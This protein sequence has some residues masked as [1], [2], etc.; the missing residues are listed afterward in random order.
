MNWSAKHLCPAVLASASLLLAAAADARVIRRYSWQSG[1]AIDPT[2]WALN[3][4]VNT[5]PANTKPTKS[6]AGMIT[7]WISGKERYRSTGKAVAVSINT[8]SPADGAGLQKIFY[9][10]IGGTNGDSPQVL[11]G[12]TKFTGF[13]VK[14]DTGWQ[15]ANGSNPNDPPGTGIY[16]NWQGSGW[17]ALQL[18]T[19]ESNGV[20]RMYLLMGNDQMRGSG[21]FTNKGGFSTSNPQLAYLTDASGAPLTFTRGEWYKI[22]VSVK[23]DPFG[24]TGRVQAWVNDAQAA[25]WTGKVGYTP[26]SYSS[27]AVP[28]TTDGTSVEVGIYQT[29]TDTNHKLFIDELRYADTFAEAQP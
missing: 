3:N 22:V 23:F 12:T 28:G 4:I 17:P 5:L 9:Q 14:F 8:G 1:T 15:L 11:A 2:T 26:S 21:G 19:D 27:T 7:P 29:D 16:Q 24:N 18:R 10:L 6:T 25:N 20:I 13:A